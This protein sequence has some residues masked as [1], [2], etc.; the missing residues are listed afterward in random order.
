MERRFYEDPVITKNIWKPGRITVRYVETNSVMIANATQNVPRCH[1]YCVQSLASLSKNDRFLIE[2][3]ACFIPVLTNTSLR[4][5]RFR[6]LSEQKK[7]RKR[8]FRFWPREKW[9][10]DPLPALLLAP[11]FARS[12]TLVPRSLLLN[13]KETLATKIRQIPVLYY[14]SVQFMLQHADT[15]SKFCFLSAVLNFW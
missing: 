2:T 5:K 4:S 13:R 3:T 7:D 8:N 14:C 9:N 1:G 10:E 11:F 15:S 12:S 6:L